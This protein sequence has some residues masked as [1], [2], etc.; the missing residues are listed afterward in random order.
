MDP[1]LSMKS[2]FH[3]STMNQNWIKFHAIPNCSQD[4]TLVL[5]HS[6]H[7]GLPLQ[8]TI[9]VAS[10]CK[11]HEG[12]VVSPLEQAT[13]CKSALAI[14]RNIVPIIDINKK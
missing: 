3:Q 5:T 10:R 1:T 12:L 4:T 11:K 2:V 9:A 6:L 13:K 7:D 14:T 8:D